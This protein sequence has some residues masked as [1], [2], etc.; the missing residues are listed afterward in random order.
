MVII[1]EIEYEDIDKGGFLEVLENLL[2]SEIDN[3]NAKNI[4]GWMGTLANPHNI[5]KDKIKSIT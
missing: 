4:A 2:S 3:K 5:K 1:R